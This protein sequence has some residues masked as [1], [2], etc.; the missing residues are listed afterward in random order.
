MLLKLRQ[1][2]NIRRSV[3]SVVD[4]HIKSSED[5]VI[6]SYNDTGLSDTELQK[7]IDNICELFCRLRKYTKDFFP[8]ADTYAIQDLSIRSSDYN[9]IKQNYSITQVEAYEQ[10]IT[11]VLNNVNSAYPN[12]SAIFTSKYAHNYA[13][14]YFFQECSSYIPFTWSSTDA[15]EIIDKC[16]EE[17]KAL[18][19]Q[20]QQ[21]VSL[22]S[23]EQQTSVQKTIDDVA[24]ARGGNEQ[25]TQQNNSGIDIKQAG[26]DIKQAGIGAAVVTLGALATKLIGGTIYNKV[27][28]IGNFS[29][30]NEMLQSPVLNQKLQQLASR[31]PSPYP[32]VQDVKNDPRAKSKST[33]MGWLLGGSS[34]AKVMQQAGSINMLV[35]QV[36]GIPVSITS[37][38]PL[39][40]NSNKILLA[41]AY[42]YKNNQIVSVPLARGFL[43]GGNVVNASREAADIFFNARGQKF[44]K[45]Q[46]QYLANKT[47][48][49]FGPVPELESKIIDWYCL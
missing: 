28:S 35:K 46:I 15:M 6:K 40:L 38:R 41:T 48:E 36:N 18:L 8:K 49:S 12:I 5:W 2:K 25:G 22:R 29:S 26:I 21:F 13:N 7:N 1:K 43:N 17:S 45:K 11:E 34:S 16:I 27:T 24:E 3:E 23:T 33:F 47:Y 44:T 31:Y 19:Y 14:K 39:T 42:F 9:Y 4:S 20:L 30:G 32:S 37:I 10:F